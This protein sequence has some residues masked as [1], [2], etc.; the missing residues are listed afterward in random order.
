MAARRNTPKAQTPT[1]GWTITT[2][3]STTSLTGTYAAA[4]AAA[5]KHLYQLADA[6]GREVYTV[7]RNG[8]EVTATCYEGPALTAHLTTAALVAA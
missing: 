7:R 6:A 8:Y 5:E 4:L 3:T 2:A 1:V